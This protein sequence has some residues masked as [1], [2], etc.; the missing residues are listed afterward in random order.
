MQNDG[1]FEFL[2]QLQL[3]VVEEFLLLSHDW[4]TQSRDKKI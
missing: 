3:R 1:E 2:R 4:L